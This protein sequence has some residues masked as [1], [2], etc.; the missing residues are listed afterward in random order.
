MTISKYLSETLWF[1]SRGYMVEVKN[2]KDSQKKYMIITQP[3]VPESEQFPVIVSQYQMRNFLEA[4]ERASEAMLPEAP[5][6]DGT[7]IPTR[8]RQAKAKPTPKSPN[9]K[10][11]KAN[12]PE[13]CNSGKR[14][15]QAADERL[16][17]Q[18]QKGVSL[19]AMTK[20]FKRR[21]K[22][23]EVRLYKLGL[24]PKDK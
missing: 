12:P 13:F 8:K 19:E 21:V 5:T 11:T 2:F 24:L 15:T 17:D 16:A 18:F 23:L 6:L 10:R 7:T 22:S 9:P 3:E 1:G 4:M 20:M 14:W